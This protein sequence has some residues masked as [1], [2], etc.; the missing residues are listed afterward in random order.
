MTRVI[1]AQPLTA[2]AFAKYGDVIECSE[3]KKELSINYGNTTRFHDLFDVDVA[4]E[5]GDVC[6]SI[7]RSHPLEQP[8]TV[9]VVEHHPLGSQAFIALGD[10]PYLV[11]VAEAG[12]F[13]AQ[14]LKVFLAH[15]GQGVNY[16]K[17]TWH[18]Y[19]LALEK[20]SDFLVMDRKGSG[21][22]CVEHHLSSDEQVAIEV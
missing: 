5:G 21:D 18:H 19:C 10:Q 7:F 17:G 6:V 16:H 3:A 11:V 20:T 15:S 14:K 1:K 9:K 13:D 2:E 12:P 4:D 22:N 8:I